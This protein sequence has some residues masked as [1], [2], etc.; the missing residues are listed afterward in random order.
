[1]TDKVS[2]SQENNR[3]ERSIN[4]RLVLLATGAAAKAAYAGPASAAM[5]GR[6]QRKHEPRYPVY[7]NQVFC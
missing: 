3:T 5:P 4:R 2:K 1:M 6:D 7:F